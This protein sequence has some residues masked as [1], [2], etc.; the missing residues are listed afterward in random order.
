MPMRNDLADNTV[1]QLFDQVCVRAENNIEALKQQR[2]QLKHLEE[3]G[4]SLTSENH[5]LR[6]AQLRLMAENQQL[7]QDKQVLTDRLDSLQERLRSIVDAPLLENSEA[8]LSMIS[9]SLD[10]SG[11]KAEAAKPKP[12]EPIPEKFSA[13]EILDQW[14]KRYPKAFSNPCMQPLKIGIHE[15]LSANESLP[16][17]WIRRALA[18]Y[19]RSPRY[20][21][22][23]K[24]GAVRQDLNGN[25]AGFI[26]EEEAGHATEQLEEIRLQRLQKE[27]ALREKEESRRLNSK[28]SQLVTKH[29]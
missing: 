21:R 26:S 24:A 2:Q 3:N 19:V 13:K 11:E 27:Q 23:L 1:D 6:A 15:D 20:L 16:D 12:Q 14:C 18:S 25:N 22:L 28:L 8:L 10:P 7:Q 17:H 4:A 9:E 5:Q 29:T